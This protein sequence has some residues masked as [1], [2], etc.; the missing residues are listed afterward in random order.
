MEAEEIIINCQQVCHGV[1]NTLP[2]EYEKSEFAVYVWLAPDTQ[3]KSFCELSSC[4]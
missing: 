4:K 3:L 2:C 1:S